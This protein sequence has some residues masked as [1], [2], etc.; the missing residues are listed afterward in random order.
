MSDTDSA[1]QPFISALPAVIFVT[2]IFFC[3]F[4][5]RVVFAPLMPVIEADLG[6]SHAGA[7]HLFLAL[8]VGNATGL[9]LSGF[10]SRAMTHRRTVGFSAIIVGICALLVPSASSYVTLL[11]A[12]LALGVAV[13]LY[14]PSGIATVTSL[15]RTGDWGKTMAVHEMAPN[16]SY[17]MAPLLAEAVLFFLDWRAALYILGAL[18]VLVGLWFIRSGRGGDF[19]GIVPGPLMVYQ[20]VKRPI[21]WL[22]VLFFS[23]AVG[24]SIGLYA[25]LPLYL[26]DAHGY[27]R[28]GANQLMAM[29]RIAACLAPFLVGWITDKW[30]AKPAIFLYLLT[31]GSA[32]VVLGFASGKLLVAMVLMQPVFS[33]FLFAP[34]FT[35]LSMVFPPEHRSVAVALMGPVNALV[36]LGLVPTFLGHMGDAGRFDTGFLAL[37]C[38]LIAAMVFLPILP[39]GRA[40]QQT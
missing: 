23:M 24:A 31:N 12:L 20:I 33:V 32:L 4:I 7:G 29:S 1:A 2:A 9:L 14:L 34:G 27:T 18:Q 28:E 26:V 21:F 13:G 11:A 3:N 6:F 5:S 16:L 10:V 40:N 30:G 38:I 35:M 37:G 8:A 15:V 39:K 25:M 36:G 22:L 19:P 17:V